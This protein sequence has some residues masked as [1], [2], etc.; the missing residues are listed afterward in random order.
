M[1][2][3][4]YVT[5][6]LKR[7]WLLRS[8]KSLIEDIFVHRCIRSERAFFHL[9]HLSLLTRHSFFSLPRADIGNTKFYPHLPN[10][11]TTPK[12]IENVL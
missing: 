6:E 10:P 7:K 12:N 2:G 1:R 4:K 8:S 5:I 3:Q 11:I 9:F